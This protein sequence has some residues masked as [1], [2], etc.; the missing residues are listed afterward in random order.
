MAVLLIK[1][2]AGT[3]CLAD[4]PGVRFVSAHV[5]STAST[6]PNASVDVAAVDDG[7]NCVLGEAG[8]CHC[9]CAHSTVLPAMA[10]VPLTHLEMRFESP[11]NSPGHA[12]DASGSLIRPPIA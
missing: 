11:A 10:M 5:P 6:S 3:V 12:P 4:G 2:V 7:G 1:L 9:A 8:G